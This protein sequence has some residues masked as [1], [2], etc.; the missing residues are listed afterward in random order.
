MNLPPVALGQTVD[1]VDVAVTF[2]CAM[3]TGGELRCWGEN[4]NGQLGLGNILPIGDDELPVSVGVI[5][6]GLRRTA[7]SPVAI[8]RA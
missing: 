1:V 4:G 7:S 6:S 5:N 3:L 2:S 8:T